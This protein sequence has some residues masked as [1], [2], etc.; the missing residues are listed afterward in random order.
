MSA[1]SSASRRLTASSTAAVWLRRHH[2]IVAIEKDEAGRVTA[3]FAVFGL[4][5]FN[6]ILVLIAG[7]VYMGASA[8][9]AR[10][11]WLEQESRTRAVAAPQDLDQLGQQRGTAV[12]HAL[13]TDTGLPPERVFLAQNDKVS[14]S[15]QKVRFEL[16]VK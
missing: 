4:V 14:T 13:V 16:A 6:V 7:F 11:A 1:S 15:E 8:E 3:A 5:T 9:Q 2:D 12:Q 10:L